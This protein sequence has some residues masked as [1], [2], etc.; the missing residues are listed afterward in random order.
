MR[1]S[2][3]LA[4]RLYCQN[5]FAQ[6]D[7]FCVPASRLMRDAGLDSWESFEARCGVSDELRNSQIY[8]RLAVLSDTHELLYGSLIQL[9]ERADFVLH[10]GDICSQHIID[11]LDCI[12]PL[13]AVLGNNDI[14]ISFFENLPFERSGTL[15]ASNSTYY[16]VHRPQD[17]SL[18][19]VLNLQFKH[20]PELIVV[21]HTHV[22]CFQLIESARLCAEPAYAY[23]ASK[24][25]YL[26]EGHHCL[27]LCSQELQQNFI[28]ALSRGEEAVNELELSCVL[29][30][31]STSRA[32][33]LY[34]KSFARLLLVCEEKRP[35][36]LYGLEFVQLDKG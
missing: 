15:A 12:A 11:E 35:C 10:A 16:M 32:R 36:C 2:L 34:G 6:L 13:Y 21:G 9:L 30:P 7:E 27:S 33:S 4:S 29:N 28:T 19:P 26:K 22:P 14:P 5:V 23:Q 17:I 24:A 8:Y 18:K 20:Y 3:H 31:G 1:I 25:S